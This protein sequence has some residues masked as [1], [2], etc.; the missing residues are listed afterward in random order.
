MAIDARSAMMEAW[1]AKGGC[2]VQSLRA[3]PW[4]LCGFGFFQAWV[5]FAVLSPASFA[6]D[7]LSGAVPHGAVMSGMLFACM[8]ALV[9]INVRHDVLSPFWV[10]PAASACAAAGTVLLGLPSGLPTLQATGVALMS[11]GSA[12]LVLGWGAA[13]A[14][15]NVDRMSEHLVV[16]SLWACVLYVLLVPLP[17]ELTRAGVTILP[18][19]SMLVLRACK[20]E[21]RRSEVSASFEILPSTKNLVAAIAAIAAG[22]SLVRSFF[23]GGSLELFGGSYRLVMMAFAAFAAVLAVIVLAF[24]RPRI[25]RLYRWSVTLVLFGLMA[26]IALP[27]DVGW[28]G[29]A[30]L[31]L[32]YSVFSEL[33][34][35]LHPA[36]KM[37]IGSFEG[38]V[39]GWGRVVLHG[40]AFAG[41]LI[42]DWLLF[43][44]GLSGEALTLAALAMTSL[45]L[46]V[47]IN[48]LP[49]QEFMLF[50]D[51]IKVEPSIAPPVSD[52]AEIDLACRRLAERVGIS[53]RELDVFM[54]LARG[55]TLPYIEEKL[56]VSNSTVRTHARSIYR[57]LDVHTKQELINL[58]EEAAGVRDEL[59]AS[60]ASGGGEA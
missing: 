37:R 54:L 16:S 58:V 56:C 29:S 18:V 26:A 45:V 17:L 41:V 40:C 21:P 33:V 2:K 55:R 19:A 15:M 44:G 6:S 47:S 59:G 20:D 42:G 51:P 8:T 36:L 52:G 22:Y 46:V 14:T 48:V 7:G 12:V 5:Y 24:G 23:M 60:K 49:G 57:K 10:L 3:K 11:L 34:W 27:K 28:L 50:I 4:R 43:Q 38:S 31:M 25:G 13:W 39:F 35:L 9:V 32:G 53:R 30:A 1:H